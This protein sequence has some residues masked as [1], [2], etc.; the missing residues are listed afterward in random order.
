MRG[1]GMNHRE[2]AAEMS[3]SYRLR[4]RGALRIAWGWTLDEAAARYNAHSAAD[5][6][7]R[8]SMRGTRLGEYETWPFGGRKPSLIVLGLLAEIYRVPVLDLVD[9]HDRGRFSP[10]ELLLLSKTTGSPRPHGAEET[11]IAAGGQVISPLVDRPDPR[12]VSPGQSSRAVLARLVLNDAVTPA[13]RHATTTLTEPGN[14]AYGR[15]QGS[16]PELSGTAILH[17]VMMAAHE[18]SE[19]AERAERRDI[20]ETTLEQIRADVIRLSHDYMTGEPWPLFQEMRRVRARIHAALDRRLWPRDETELY[21]LLAVLN[22]L[23]A[24]AAKD[25]G[26]PRAAEELVRSGWAFAVLIDN[27]PLMAQLRVGMSGIAYWSRPRQ[28]AQ[29]AA[30]GLEYLSA[31]PNGAQLHL[32]HARAAARFGD[33]NEARRAI[34]AASDAREH[35][36]EDDLL[37]IGGEFGYSRA[38]QHYHAGST[39]VEIPDAEDD[40]LTELELAA[41]LYA[42][43]PEPGEDHSKHAEMI[44]RIDLGTAQ[45]RASR[46]DAATSALAPVLALPRNKRIDSLPQRFGRVRAELADPRY[47]GS[48]QAR[49]LDERIEHFCSET[50]LGDLRELG[51]PVGS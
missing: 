13:P 29:Y 37:E 41:E 33:A 28:S 11:A 17:E 22:A 10:R 51:A 15:I 50:I 5:P 14:F 6:E 30:N 45:L 7:G 9:I 26:S 38:T 1:L 43:G 31:G 40:A 48:G 44:A 42:A 36:H 49:E 35:R 46:L 16:E 34:A 19:H 3:R 18:G 27:R 21:F 39:L 32:M 23:M 12:P 8:A 25:L 20:G 2:I 24:V 47:H 4:P